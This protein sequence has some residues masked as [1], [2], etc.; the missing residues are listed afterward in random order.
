MGIP[1]AKAEDDI[2]GIKA[3]KGQKQ[4]GS[5]CWRA[6][7]K[8][9]SA[10]TRRITSLFL[11]AFLER[12]ALVYPAK[13]AIVDGARIITY[14]DMW[15][16]CRQASD[17][18]RKAGVGKDDT[19]SVFSPNGVATLEMHY[20]ASMAGGVLNA[21]NYRL[22]AKTVGFILKHAETKAFLVDAELM[23]VARAALAEIDHPPV[24]VEIGAPQAGHPA[25][26]DCIEYEDFLAGGDPAA[27]ID[28]PEDEW[29]AIALNY[30]SGTTGNPKG[31]VYHHRG[32]YLCAFGQAVM[33]GL[34]PES[35][36]LWT[37]PMFHCNG[38]C[39][40]WAVTLAG[41]THVIQRAIV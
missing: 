19:V 18:L 28:M 3:R 16:R 6:N 7:M 37:V 17:A 24:L 39:Y 36:H 4:G 38:W 30:T 21:M 5:I 13:P 35:V 12:S 34:G 20:A 1:P 29:H 31:V 23:P 2:L 9:P 22:D 27:P 10:R 33:A 40:S 15:R 26:G 11:P 41:G 32:A 25:K 8:P 14:A